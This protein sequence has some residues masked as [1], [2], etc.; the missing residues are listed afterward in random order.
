MRAFVVAI[1]LALARIAHATGPCENTEARYDPPE[2]FDEST[3][4]FAVPV[5]QPWCAGDVIDEKR[6]TVSFVELRDTHDKVVTITATPL[7]ACF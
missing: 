6:G 4:S 5:S 3:Q 1:V 2:L 7:A